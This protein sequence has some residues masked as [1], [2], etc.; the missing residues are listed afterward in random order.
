MYLE[1]QTDQSSCR[2][3]QRREGFMYEGGFSRVQTHTVSRVALGTKKKIY[4]T[5]LG[6]CLS[7]LASNALQGALI[8]FRG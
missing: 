2:N 1:Y 5:T 8:T 4:R 7:I 3:R 6:W